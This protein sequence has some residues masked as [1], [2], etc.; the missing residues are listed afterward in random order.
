MIALIVNTQNEIHRV[1]YDPP[2]YDVIKK[3]VGG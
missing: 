1:E 2:H 3:A